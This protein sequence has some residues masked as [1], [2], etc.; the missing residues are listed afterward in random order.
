MSLFPA[1]KFA[2]WTGGKGKKT[3]GHEE[4]WLD[5]GV[6]WPKVG[7]GSVTPVGTCIR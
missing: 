1:G 3:N 5:F 7:E 6:V 4:L 2:S